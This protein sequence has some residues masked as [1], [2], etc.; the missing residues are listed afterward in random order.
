MTQAE[1]CYPPAPKPAVPKPKAEAKPEAAV[2]T[3]SEALLMDK[4]KSH[5]DKVTVAAKECQLSDLSSPC[6]NLR[7]V[8]RN[9]RIG[10]D[11]EVASY[12]ERQLERSR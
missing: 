10:S 6:L 1:E 2:G 5:T 11:R 8:D 3:M 4:L 12:R 9:T 7:E